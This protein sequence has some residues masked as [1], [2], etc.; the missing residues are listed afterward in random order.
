MIRWSLVVSEETDKALRTYLA[1]SGGRKDDLSRFIEIAVR[2][3]LFHLQV[4][5]I[6]ERNQQYDQQEILKTVD[7]A[8]E[9][10]HADRH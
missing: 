2:D 7:E 3:K 6:K 10:A 5:Q 1:Q 9:W 4:G 8:V